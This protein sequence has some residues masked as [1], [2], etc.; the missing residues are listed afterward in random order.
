MYFFSTA[1]LAQ[2]VRRAVIPFYILVMKQILLLYCLGFLGFVMG[3]APFNIAY[4]TDSLQKTATMFSGMHATDSC[5]Y[6]IG[7]TVKDGAN[8]GFLSKIN[9]NGET[10][11]NRVIGNSSQP[12]RTWN[13][14]FVFGNPFIATKDNNF[15]MVGINQRNRPF[16]FLLKSNKEGG[17]VFAK[18][19]SPQDTTLFYEFSTIIEAKEGGYYIVGSEFYHKMPIRLGTGKLLRLDN[20]GNILWIKTFQN[21]TWD[22]GAWDI[23]QKDDR[24]YILASKRKSDT[25][26][27]DYEQITQLFITDTLGNIIKQYET[28]T[29]RKIEAYQMCVLANGNIAISGKEYIQE[30]L[31]NNPYAYMAVI[32]A[33]LSHIVWDKKVEYQGRKIVEKPNG[34]L[35]VAIS[36]E[37]QLN[38]IVQNAACL[39]ELDALT[40]D[41][42]CQ[43]FYKTPMVL[44]QYV[45]RHINNF[46]LL[47]DGS[48]IVA[49]QV[50]DSYYLSTTAGYWGWLMRT[51]ANGNAP[52]QVTEIVLPTQKEV[53]VKVYPNPAQE[54]ATVEY[55]LPEYIESAILTISDI[56]GKQITEWKLDKYKGEVI[57]DTREI[58]VGV[59]LL[60]IS[61]NNTYLFHSKI[62]I[63][64]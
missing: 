13:G 43:R 16:A 33:S 56:T 12:F 64:K 58:P 29:N 6:T 5:Y 40:G 19:Y 49:G 39:Y 44:G 52:G 57:W 47:S 46:E 28:P 3:Q 60:Q 36:A 15:A 53:K 61:H 31:A 41:S 51:D 48:L 2:I 34:N 10:V 18:E 30:N 42:I 9:L 8:V 32:D 21:T 37:V 1:L 4:R 63:I 45:Y 11:F 26:Q 20:Q 50:E 55:H 35:L 22:I 54:L 38:G 7:V 17:I 25:T 59:Y 27:P 24:L 14:Y 62:T 23:I